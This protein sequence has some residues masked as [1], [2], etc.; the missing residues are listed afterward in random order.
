MQKNTHIFSL[1]VLLIA[2]IATLGVS[3]SS[4]TPKF[5]S[6]IF[7]TA[8]PI[9][10][11]L[12]SG[13]AGKIIIPTPGYGVSENPS[14]TGELMLTGQYMFLETAG[15]ITLTD[16]DTNLPT[17]PIGVKF[18]TIP[19]NT[20]ITEWQ[21][22]AGQKLYGWS[23]N[24]GWIDFNPTN[25]SSGLIFRGGGLAS[26]TGQAWSDT[27]GW[28][29]FSEA[30]VDFLNKVKV[31]GNIGGNKTFDVV[32]SVGAKFDSTSVNDLLNTIRK[33]IALM[34]RAVT[35]STSQA[36]ATINTE[37]TTTKPL[38]NETIVYRF[39]K[40]TPPLLDNANDLFNTTGNQLRSIIIIG[41]DLVIDGDIA[42]GKNSRAIIVMKNEAGQ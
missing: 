8:Q 29:D 6:G 4:G 11:F 2:S 38:N 37:S 20:T 17:D 40:S 35:I 39:N 34:T 23:D 41:G 32:Y 26:F 18:S 21:L 14:N 19:S 42:G 28:L 33:N 10:S 27:L 36:D 13:N 15:W 31:I 25:V 7:A 9:G 5:L 16:D 30:Y 24:A 22:A 1:S 3:W 12:P